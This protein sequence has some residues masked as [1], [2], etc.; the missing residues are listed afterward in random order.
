MP[1]ALK[2]PSALEALFSPRAVAFIGVS[3]DP[4][5]YSGRALRFLRAHG[6]AGSTYAVNPKYQEVLGAPCVKSTQ[7]L[8]D[9]EIDLAFIAVSAERVIGVVEECGRKG[10]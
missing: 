10:I 2:S 8:P 6:F 5:K 9:G 1:D 4:M 3:P 7:D